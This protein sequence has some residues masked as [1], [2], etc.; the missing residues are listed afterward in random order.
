[1][2]KALERKAFQ[3]AFETP[4]AANYEALCDD[5]K[6]RLQAMVLMNL[7]LAWRAG[8]CEV[9]RLRS[10]Q[11][12]GRNEA[13]FVMLAHDLSERSKK[14]CLESKMFEGACILVG[15]SMTLVGRALSRD[16]TGVV[17]LRK[18]RISERV[19]ADLKRLGSMGAFL[20]QGKFEESGNG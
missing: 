12:V 5:I 15:P 1:L 19:V 13:S 20:S 6:N 2:K 18:G 3:R 7:G 4:V 9:G 8:Q 11:D 10:A 17:A 16:E 14:E